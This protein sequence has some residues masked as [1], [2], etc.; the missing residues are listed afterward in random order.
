[1]LGLE[2][3]KRA[4]YINFLFFS[5]CYMFLM[6]VQKQ[7]QSRLNDREKFWDEQSKELIKRSVAEGVKL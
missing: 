2:N 5:S 1:M 4:R 6:L 7:L 3:S